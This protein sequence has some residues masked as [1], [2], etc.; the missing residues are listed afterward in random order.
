MSFQAVRS[1]FCTLSIAFVSLTGG[2]AFGAD[3]SYL[4]GVK[5]YEA[6]DYAL[7]MKHFGKVD[8]KDDD[9]KDAYLMAADAARRNG[10]LETAEKVYRKYVKALPNDVRGLNEAAWYFATIKDRSRRDGSFAAQCATLAC[11]LTDYKSWIELDTAAAAR[12]ELGDFDLA[13]KTQELAL[14]MHKAGGTPAMR[15]RL[16]MYRTRR[17]VD[18]GFAAS[19]REGKVVVY[20]YTAEPVRI[21]LFGIK[22]GAK[23]IRRLNEVYLDVDANKKVGVSD[24]D[25]GDLRGNQVSYKVETVNGFVVRNGM[26][27]LS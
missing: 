19:D 12:A 24:P 15:S 14:K 27:A 7:A 26:T 16:A 4:S 6:G 20:N 13:V 2:F 18:D 21:T 11:Q 5:A 17:S 25:A 3:A 23:N 9:A 8:A 10:Q 1:Q 22:D